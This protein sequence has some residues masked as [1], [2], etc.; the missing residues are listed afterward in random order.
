[1]RNIAESIAKLM[2]LAIDLDI[3]MSHMLTKAVLWRKTQL[4][5]GVSHHLA[6]HVLCLMLNV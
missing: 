3:P 2:Q 4:L 1:M 5:N 6:V